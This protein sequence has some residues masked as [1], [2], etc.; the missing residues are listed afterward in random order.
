MDPATRSAIEA[1]ARLSEEASKR[2]DAVYLCVMV[3]LA[4]MVLTLIF[5]VA[6]VR[7]LPKFLD[8]IF[9]NFRDQ[10]SLLINHHKADQELTRGMFERHWEQQAEMYERLMTRQT[11]S[12]R[13]INDGY[14]EE[15]DAH[16]QEFARLAGAIERLPEGIMRLLNNQGKM[17]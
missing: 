9:D 1:I 8:R 13:E 12:V 7:W 14:R 11:D 3:I 5:G 4:V 15:F 2:S 17:P 16:R 6:I 10:Y